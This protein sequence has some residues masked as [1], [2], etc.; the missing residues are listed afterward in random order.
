MK[1][2]LLL[3]LSAFT[4]LVSFSQVK[5]FVHLDSSANRPLIGRLIVSTT[6]DTANGF[7][8]GTSNTQPRFAVNLTNWTKDKVIEIND[9]A[10]TLSVKPSQMKPGYYK[11]IGTMDA[12]PERGWFNPG[13]F[14]S[15]NEPLLQVDENGK[16]EIHIWLNREVKPRPFPASDSIRLMELR[17]SL[18]SDFHKKDVFVKAGVVLPPGYGKDTAKQYP[19]VF[20]IPGWGGT[21]YD[22]LNKDR[23]VRYG[24]RTG[25]EKI[26][27][28]LNPETQTRWGL[29]SFVDSRVNG[30]WAKA[31]VEEVIPYIRAAYR[32]TG[33]ASQTFVMGQ[34]SGGYPSL[35]LPLHYPD[36]FGGGWAVSP[37]PVDFSNFTNVNLYEKSA[38]FYYNKDG[39][40]RG[41]FLKDGKYQNIVKNDVAA[42]MFEDDGT[43]TQAFEAEF[44]RLGKDGRPKQLFNRETGVVDTDVVEDWKPYDL[45]L[46]LQNNW[47]RLSGKLSGKKLHVYAGAA[48]N[49]HL[50]K[51]VE[52]LKAKADA[53]KADIVVEIIPNADHWSIW[54]KEFTERVQK[55]V[56]A[57]IE[58]AN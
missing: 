3:T 23:R 35:W 54:S 47:K 30:P 33:K 8:N 19:V 49:F 36:A 24:M 39:S 53:M 17:S 56:D 2:I 37:D 16:G 12:N 46:F 9:E 10:E 20:V 7:R 11:V 57:L 42:E 27:V 26:F 50:N 52:A 41:A 5:I 1:S 21:H 44:G 45:G 13:S 28:Y 55:E 6:A 31:L 25:S 4:S 18:L 40:L 34:S 48:D 15:S 43:Q 58:A 29:H 38:N 51:S 14:Y 32:T 22:V